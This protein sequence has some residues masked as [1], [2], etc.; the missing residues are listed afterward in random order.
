MG[1]PLILMN[2]MSCHVF[3]KNTLSAVILTCQS[4][5]VPIYPS[6]LFIIVEAEEAGLDN[7]PVNVK[8]KRKSVGLY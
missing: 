1:I 3:S 7:V 2:I 8:K 4:T 5:L 6:K